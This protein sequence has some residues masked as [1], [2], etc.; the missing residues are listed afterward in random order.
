[1]KSIIAINENTYFNLLIIGP[2]SG[3]N[4]FAVQIRAIYSK[5]NAVIETYSNLFRHEVMNPGILSKVD[6]I[7]LITLIIMIIMM[8][9][10]N[11]LLGIYPSSS[12]L[13][14]LY[15]LLFNFK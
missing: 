8:V 4:K 5:V 15:I 11:I 7:T 2:L 13:I 9:K 1:M 6:R 12:T 10:S 14:I 3:Y